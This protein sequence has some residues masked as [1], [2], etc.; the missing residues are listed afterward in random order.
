MLWCWG[1]AEDSPLLLLLLLLLFL[2]CGRDEGD[3]GCTNE[4]AFARDGPETMEVNKR[5]V[6]ICMMA[7]GW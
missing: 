1:K 5:Q 4:N 2:T 6:D 7:D 3:M